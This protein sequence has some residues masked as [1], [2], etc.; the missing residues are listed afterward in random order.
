MTHRKSISYAVA[1]LMAVPAVVSF[2]TSGW[3]QISEIVVTTRKREESLQDLPIAVHVLS[4][5]DIVRLHITDVADVA[6]FSPSLI[7]NPGGFPNDHKI[8]IRGIR[9][10]RGRP[11]AAFLV[12]GIDVTSQSISQRGNSMLATSRLL[13]VERVEVVMGPQA[14][15]YGRTAFGGAVQFISKDPSDEFE[16]HINADIGDYGRYD[17]SGGIS[18]P[19]IADVLGLRLNATWWDKEGFYREKMTLTHIGGGEGW[20]VAGIAKWNVSDRLSFKA[21]AEY[22]S[23]EFDEV[24]RILLLDNT[25]L[26][27]SVGCRTSPD[28][29]VSSWFRDEP[30]APGAMCSGS[31]NPYFF[32]IVPDNAGGRMSD[33]SSP[34][35]LTGK[36]YEGTW[37]DLLRTSLV[38]EW[39]LDFG[40][41]TAWTG[42]T[43][44]D[45]GYVKDGSNG[46]IAV[47]PIGM[48]TDTL[49]RGQRSDAETDT[50]QFSQEI[51]FASDWENS[52]VQVTLGALYFEEKVDRISRNISNSVCHPGPNNDTPPRTSNP[53]FD[54]ELGRAL[55]AQEIF[56]NVIVNPAPIG[57][58]VDSWSVYGLVEWP[59]LDEW[60]V[61]AEAR[62]SRE[63]E[64]SMGWDCDPVATAV[65][66][67]FGPGACPRG[68]SSV[69]SDLIHQAIGMSRADKH[70]ERFVTPRY[71]LEWTPN[72]A[73]L[74]YAS[75]GKAVKPG[76]TNVVVSGT[77]SDLDFDG[78]VEE[79][80]FKR[81]T[82]WAYEIGTKK[83]WLDGRLRTNGAVFYQHYKGRQVSTQQPDCCGSSTSLILNAGVSE[84]YGVEIDTLWH[85]TDNWT[86]SAAYTYLDATYK[87]FI[88]PFS[89]SGGTNREANNCTPINND[90]DA[91]YDFCEISFSGNKLEGI[92]EHSFVG[93]VRYRAPSAPIA[94]LFGFDSSLD[95]FIE[96]SAR[97]MGKRWQ[98]E[99]N[100]IGLKSYTITD[101]RVGLTAEKWE[102][103]FY[104]DNLFDDDTVQQAEDMS[105]GLG[106]E[107]IW[108]G[109]YDIPIPGGDPANF[110][111]SG[112]PS[113][114]GS[115][116]A[117]LPDPLTFGMRISV[118]Y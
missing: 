100:Q 18:G 32:G 105:S 54:A 62:I 86:L 7:Y 90:S 78:D 53:C 52:P 113:P 55:T 98:D 25:W 31:A 10:T 104:V 92:P 103:L 50:T 77:W 33:I 26:N 84:I 56:P 29:L 51:R 67:G 43:S 8:I 23:D 39:D 47:G 102:L 4:A 97:H 117:F 22:S 66:P 17:V 21:R 48:M 61:T 85:A 81:E 114:T 42:F 28:G 101:L 80:K 88:N 108:R 75:A 35:P 63:T 112:S 107:L 91:A 5:Q 30:R 64:I 79:N 82:L 49:Q 72:D 44:A 83:T 70:V 41:I 24:A 65:Q 74:I 16:A 87:E 40:T 96:S 111:I 58:D 27:G 89:S 19:V 95:W 11:S 99:F 34:D 20:G 106:R 45:S 118:R 57:R 37:R 38:T 1:L 109:L 15:L 71:T 115:A 6:D 76:G 9:N 13:D 73:T 94:N 116:M 46:S 3:T 2:P 68:P 59:F 36:P 12:D 60:K 93:T 110:R 69:S 14:A